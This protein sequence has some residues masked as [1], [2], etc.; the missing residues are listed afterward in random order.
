MQEVAVEPM[1]RKSIRWFAK[2]FRELFGMENVLYFPIVQFIEWVLPE[3]GLDYEYA[4]IQEMGDAYGVTHTRKGIMTIRED[5]YE[6]AIKGNPRD[7]FTLCHELGHFLMH[8]PERVSFPRGDVPKY[9]N[10]EWQASAFAGEL[11]APYE[12]V[13]DMNIS[14]I[15]QKC[16]MSLSAAKVQYDNYHKAV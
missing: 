8:S 4:S 2:K 5:V 9:M 6:R 13:K 11:L 16:G 14:E 7:R 12:L 15:A 1:S 3:L 10:P